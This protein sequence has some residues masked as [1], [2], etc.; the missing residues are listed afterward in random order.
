MLLVKR[1]TPTATVPTKAHFNDAGFDLY[2]DIP[3]VESLELT[4]GTPTLVSTGIS[5]NI[6]EGCYG[7]IAGRSGLAVKGIDVFGG[8]VDSGYRGEVKVVLNNLNFANQSYKLKHGERV[9]QLV[10]E[11]ISTAPVQEVAELDL[12]D[13]GG[14]GFG[15]TGK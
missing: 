12:T 6:P 13:R 11:R 2:A 4:F 8:V 15:S 10:I 9:A 3:T 14:N 7:R 1:L 5:V